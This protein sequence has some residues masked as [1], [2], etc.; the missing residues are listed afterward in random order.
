MPAPRR[1]V[2]LELG[3]HGER[4]KITAPQP[5]HRA[6]LDELLPLIRA[7]DDAMIGRSAASEPIS[8]KAGCSACCRAQPVP[9]TP[10]EANALRRLVSSLPEPRRSAVLA[11]FKNA[12]DRL[13]AAGLA[14]PFLTRDPAVS[15][16]ESVAIAR[17]V[18][19]LGL[20]CPFLDNDLCSIYA[21]RPFVCRHYLVT[22]PA[23]HCDDPFTNEVRRIPLPVTPAAAA[24]AM[25][26]R[27]T[28]A[29][30]YTVPLVIALEFAERHKSELERTY[31]SSEVAREWVAKMVSED[32][33]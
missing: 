33:D 23:S 4:V 14:E 28:R 10:P 15:P 21:E 27:K 25:T 8:C 5:P 18:Y 6:R 3:I 19:D 13:H 2:T 7:I 12:A 17:K 22:T 16:E 1:Q 31:P 26:E 9:V 29:P 11:R 32:D 24:L 30:G 20:V